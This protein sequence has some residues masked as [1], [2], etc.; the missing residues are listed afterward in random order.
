MD[1]WAT[2]SLTPQITTGWSA[3]EELFTKLFPMDLRPQGQD[4]IRTW[5]FST[6]V[7]AHHEHGSLPWRHA[8]ISGW[9][10]DPD[11]KKMSKSKG[12]AQTPEELLL[13][14]GSDAVRY[15]A[16]SARLGTDAAFDTGQMKIGR[17]LAIKVL[18][19]SKFALGF[20][21]TPTGLGAA[22][23]LAE[24]RA[25]VTDPLDRAMLA[26]LARVVHSATRGLAEY[27][28]TRA[29]QDT[30]TF[31]WSFCD[32]YIELVKDRAHGV[33]CPAGAA[34]ARA[35]LQL[36][37]DVLL[38]L[39][40]PFLPFATEEV[41]SWWRPGSVHRAAWPTADE[42][43][44]DTDTD[45]DTDEA[46][47]LHVVGQALAGVRKAKSDA[48]LGMRAEVVSVTI[49]GPDA[50]LERIRAAEQDLRAAGR[51]DTLTYAPAEDLRVL[52]AVLAPATP[53]R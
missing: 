48:K 8:A 21:S 39:L 38:R 13:R 44:A 10:L 19:A 4:I 52:H 6:V 37:L 51:I 12:N 49:A 25:A 7:R 42:L 22:G 33:R 18:N 5:L 31:F 11:R 47:A 41:W 27:D 30:E 29:L 23:D 1:T 3:D 17:R 40:A 15:W 28:H 24:L 9:I 50:V 2:S 46:A 26:G 14:H 16:C 35:A 36:A 45:T 20:G 43:G 53:R 34:S 32:D